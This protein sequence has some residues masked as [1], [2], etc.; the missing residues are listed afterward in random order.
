MAGWYSTYIIFHGALVILIGLFSG[1]I[2][3]QT[4]LREK[5]L[6]TI[7][8]WRIAHVFLSIEGM[9]L[10]TVGLIIPNLLLGDLGLRGLAWIMILSG[11]GFVWAFVGGAFTGHRGL[12]PMPCGLNTLLFLGHF[13]GAV[14]SLIGMAIVVYGAIQTIF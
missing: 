3:W 6:E 8:G 1:V 10:M 9:F 11:Y 2:Y 5:G 12:K 4:I 13:I 14:G 7:R